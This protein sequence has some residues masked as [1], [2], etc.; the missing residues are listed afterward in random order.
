MKMTVLLKLPLIVLIKSTLQTS[1]LASNTTLLFPDYA[2]YPPAA[3]LR[4]LIPRCD[5]F[6]A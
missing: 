6:F 4:C 1:A 3:F 5:A 2:Y